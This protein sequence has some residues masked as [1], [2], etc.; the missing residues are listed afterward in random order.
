MNIERAVVILYVLLDILQEEHVEV[1]HCRDIMRHV[2]GYKHMG[3]AIDMRD[4]GLVALSLQLY[5]LLVAEVSYIINPKVRADQ[6]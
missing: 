4:A 1:D 3:L 2:V 5:L 6:V